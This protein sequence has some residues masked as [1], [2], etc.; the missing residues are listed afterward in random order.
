MPL[1]DEVIRRA[2]LSSTSAIALLRP[3][4]S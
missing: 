3:T 4:A 2:G 1:V